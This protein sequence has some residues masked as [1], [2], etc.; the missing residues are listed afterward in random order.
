[1]ADWGE[2]T[3]EMERLLR[4]QT[5]PVAYKRFENAEDLAKVPKV[6]RFDRYLTLCQLIALVRIRGWTV[7]VTTE[8]KLE[9]RCAR[10]HG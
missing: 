3:R 5:F 10:I 9:S 6:R 4:L 7:G 8:D 2:L 1:M